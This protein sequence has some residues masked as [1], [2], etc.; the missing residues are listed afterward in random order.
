[1]AYLYPPGRTPPH[2][3]PALFALSNR[4]QTAIDHLQVST[5]PGQRGHVFSQVTRQCGGPK[6]RHQERKLADHKE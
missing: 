5:R 2:C 3:L 6:T 4:S 1:M